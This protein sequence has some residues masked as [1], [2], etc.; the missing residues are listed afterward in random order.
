VSDP[1]GRLTIGEFA[2]M[3]GISPSALRFYH[4]CGLVAPG[5]IDPVTG[6]RYYHRHQLAQVLVIR[7]LRGAGL[8]LAEVRRMFDAP[9]SVVREMLR[10]RLGQAERA[11]Q[12]A[13]AS[14]AAAMSL[15]EGLTSAV[16][17]VP[18]PELADTVR[19]VCASAD[20]GA[21]PSGAFAVLA[22]VLVEVTGQE[23]TLVATDRYRLVMESLP[24]QHVADLTTASRTVV[25]AV[26]LDRLRPWLRRQDTVRLEF[27][28]Q[29]PGQPEQP[30]QPGSGRPLLG[31]V[32]A[33]GRREL[34]VIPADFPDYRMLLDGLPAPTTRILASRRALLAAADG[35]GPL[36]WEAD[37]GQGLRVIRP[38]AEDRPQTV[39]AEIRGA[40]VVLGFDPDRLRAVLVHGVGPDLGFEITR[41]DRPVVVRCA[42]RTGVTTLLM[43]TAPGWTAPGPAAPGPGVPG[44][45]VPGPAA[46]AHDSRGAA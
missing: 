9:P 19:R 32:S 28:E 3:T 30:E 5:E 34:A 10:D 36:R 24:L 13:R 14:A 6:Y 31:L 7:H 8:P 16:V 43:P 41:P 35:P 38:G 4:D 42:D 26:E 37:P 21:D 46:S 12:D 33:R 2:R 23:L 27:A 29:Q 39:D 18:G 40:G 44:P 22:G 1:R 45:G 15:L 25:P 11:L 20:G 17:A